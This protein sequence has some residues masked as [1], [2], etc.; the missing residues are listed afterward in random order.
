MEVF[1]CIISRNSIQV[2]CMY[3]Y[4]SS[5]NYLFSRMQLTNVFVILLEAVSSYCKPFRRKVDTA[6]SYRDIDSI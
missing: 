6:D 2:K 4:L 1:L 5:E 3:S